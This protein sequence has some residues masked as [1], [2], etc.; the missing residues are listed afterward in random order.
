MVWWQRPLSSTFWYQFG[1]PWTLFKVT[2][3]W[4]FSVHFLANVGF[5]L[6]EIQYVAATCL[7]KFMLKIFSTSTVQG[8]ELCWRD[9]M[10]CTFHRHVSGHLW[11]DFKLGMILNTTEINSFMPVWLT[12]MFTQDHRK[13]KVVKSF[14]CKVAWI[15]SS[16]HIGWSCKGDEEVL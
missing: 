10:K 3:E 13:S 14:C 11:T 15:S 16:V 6:D 12:L 1:W 9:F 8:R 2:V 5:D 4:K 7:F